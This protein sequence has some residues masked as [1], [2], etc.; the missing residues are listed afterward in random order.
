MHGGGRDELGR[1]VWGG[2]E[3]LPLPMDELPL[4]HQGKGE[5]PGAMRSLT[6]RGLPL[7][8]QGKG[9]DP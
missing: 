8:Y 5:D 2:E 3:K 4:D 6:S 7:D 1:R 9:E